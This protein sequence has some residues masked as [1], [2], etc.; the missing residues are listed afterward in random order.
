VDGIWHNQYQGEKSD[1]SVFRKF[2]T[3]DVN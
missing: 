2:Y 1:F 3:K